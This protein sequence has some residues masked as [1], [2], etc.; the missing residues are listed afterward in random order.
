MNALQTP[1]PFIVNEENGKKKIVQSK[2]V[3]FLEANGFNQVLLDGELSYIRENNR[4]IREISIVEIVAFL[5][6]LLDNEEYADAYDVY[7]QSMHSYIGRTKLLLLKPIKP[8]DDRD[9]KD[10][11]RFY[12]KNCF[13]EI[14]AESI[15]IKEYAS[16]SNTI[17]EQRIIPRSY[18][19][20]DTEEVGQFVQFCSNITG[21]DPNR[22]KALQSFVGYLLHRNKERG[23]NKAII[24]YDEQMGLGNRANG[25]TGKTLLGKAI[26]QCRDLIYYDGKNTVFKGNFIYQR[27]THTTDV[28]YYDDLPKNIEF[29]TFYSYL[30]TGIQIE[31]KYKSAFYIKEERAPKLLISSNHYVKGDGGS[32]DLGRRYEFEVVNYYDKDFMPE[33][34][35]GNRF[36]G[37]NWEVSEWNKFY[38]FMMECVQIYLVNGLIEAEPINLK[39]NKIADSTSKQF[40]EFA[41]AY[42]TIDKRLDKRQLIEDFKEF[43]P[44]WKDISSHQFT[45]WCKVYSDQN[46]LFYRDKPSGGDYYCWFNSEYVADE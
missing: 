15:Q 40:L 25:R 36:F 8:A 38:K 11:S 18:N 33:H 45:K 21:H 44:V 43:F 5:R 16:L 20:P 26:E 12:F 3:R 13:C 17:W 24:L 32:S 10:L 46:S 39:K 19:D 37:E 28:V 30:T 23:D 34:E 7:A 1:L 9:S 31:K 41:E 2:L 27:I 14:T 4:I 22:F 29:E 42:F 6:Q 35:F